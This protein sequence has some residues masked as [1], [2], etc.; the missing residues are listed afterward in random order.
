MSREAAGCREGYSQRRSGFSRG[1]NSRKEQA[2]EQLALEK[3]RL[4]QDILLHAQELAAEMNLRLLL[5]RELGLGGGKKVFYVESVTVTSIIYPVER[6]EGFFARIKSKF[7]DTLTYF[8]G[9]LH[10]K[11]RSKGHHAPKEQE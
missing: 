3:E 11:R 4:Q 8:G 5:D 7:K 6:R 9:L 2:M 10:P 1:D